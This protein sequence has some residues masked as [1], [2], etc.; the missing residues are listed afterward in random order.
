MS[1][2]RHIC[3]C[4]C[5]PLTRTS[6]LYC[7]ELYYVLFTVLTCAVYDGEESGRRTVCRG[8]AN[9]APCPP[10]LASSRLPAGPGRARPAGR[11][12]LAR[13]YSISSLINHSFN[14]SINH[15][16]NHQQSVRKEVS[17]KYKEIQTHKEKKKKGSR[18]KE[19]IIFLKEK[20]ECLDTVTLTFKAPSF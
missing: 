7:T 3:K 12:W 6:V 11:A 2:I 20:V 17:W 10:G 4:Q 13:V 16:S 14:Q 9:W 8:G 5:P 15:L 18:K 1:S 19:K